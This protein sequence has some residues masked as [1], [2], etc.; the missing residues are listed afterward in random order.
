MKHIKRTPKCISY[1]GKKKEE[2]C[3]GDCKNCPDLNCPMNTL[4]GGE[5][6]C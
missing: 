1:V 2:G 3:S 6:L 5:T 4:K